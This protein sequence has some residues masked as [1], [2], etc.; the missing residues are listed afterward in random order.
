V[1]RW[2]KVFKS[3]LN[4][5]VFVVSQYSP[6]NSIKK[7][8][9]AYNLDFI[10]INLKGVTSKKDFLLKLAQVLNFPAY[11]GEN[12]DALSES[13]TDLSWRPA[14]GYVILLDNFQS[15]PLNIAADIPTIKKIFKSSAIF[16]K[17]KKVPFFVV[18][19]EKNPESHA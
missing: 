7:A 11:F 19:L 8:A 6:N 10:Q 17:E 12:W 15:L 9:D 16:W 13:L 1:G 4:S 5:G 2:E 14:S 18:L 3:Y